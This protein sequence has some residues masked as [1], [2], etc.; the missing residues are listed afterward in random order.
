MKINEVAKL[1][2]ISRRTL[3]Y[4][5][6][7]NLLSPSRKTENGY[8]IYSRQDLELLQQIMFFKEMDFTLVDIKKI[9][10]A[11]DYRKSDALKKQREILLLKKN[12]LESLIKLIDK[13]LNK[14]NKLSFKEFDMSKVNDLKIKYR[15]EVEKKWGD[16]PAYKECKEKTSLY[17]KDDWDKI[18]KESD[19]IYKSLASNMQKSPKDK[20]VQQLIEKWRNHISKYYYNCTYEIFYG[21]GQMYISDVRFKKNIDRY[22]QGLAEFMHKAIKEYCKNT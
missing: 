12:R 16:T 5:D 17:T 20:E 7:I 18:K 2:N 13:T 15:K 19:T 4:Y 21:L 6:K 14:N 11:S 10:N 22:S 9:V 8:R 1:A 3:H